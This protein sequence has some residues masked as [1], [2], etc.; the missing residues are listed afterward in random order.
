MS[1]IHTCIL[2]RVNPFHYLT[3]LQRHPSELFKNPKQW[4]SWNYL[5]AVI[6][7]A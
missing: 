5:E 3:T 6:N 4:L 2:N 1:L 7:P